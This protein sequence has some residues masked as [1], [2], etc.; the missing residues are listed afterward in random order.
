MKNEADAEDVAQEAIVRAFR[1]LLS[2]L[3]RDSARG[4]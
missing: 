4:S 1:N 2:V 3:K